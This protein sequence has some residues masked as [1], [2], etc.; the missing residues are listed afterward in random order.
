MKST[1]STSY[2]TRN[3]GSQ[4]HTLLSVFTKVPDGQLPKTSKL[5][6]LAICAKNVNYLS[7][8]IQCFY[9]IG[10]S[11]KFLRLNIT[12]N[13]KKTSRESVFETFGEFPCCQIIKNHVF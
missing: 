12:K 8:V 5:S 10:F 4:R 9:Q 6:F 3:H 11:A 7:F 1:G 2:K 13:K